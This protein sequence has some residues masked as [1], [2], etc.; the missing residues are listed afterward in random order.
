MSDDRA[1]RRDAKWAARYARSQAG[2]KRLANRHDPI[3]DWPVGATAV[4]TVSGPNGETRRLRLVAPGEPVGEREY[5]L[6]LRGYVGMF[7]WLPGRWGTKA[8]ND[9][10]VVLVQRQRGPWRGFDTIHNASFDKA[11][12][13]AAY[14]QAV[15]RC[16]EAGEPIPPAVSS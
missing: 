13:A 6:I 1:K 14:L 3:F 2:M 10:W 5:P 8:D 4:S 15:R 9:R 12:D 7:V 11:A 16:I